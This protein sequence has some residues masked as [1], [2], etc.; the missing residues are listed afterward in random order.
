MSGEREAPLSDAAPTV[1][2]ADLLTAEEI[3]ARFGT[4]VSTVCHW[5]AAGLPYIRLGRGLRKYS[6]A[7]LRFRVVDV[8][9]WWQAAQRE[10]DQFEPDE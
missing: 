5:A 7:N 4:D 6:V 3:A 10:L 9:S 1:E 8:D 2:T